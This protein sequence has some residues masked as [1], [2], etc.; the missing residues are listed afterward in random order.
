MSVHGSRRSAIHFISGY[1]FLIFNPI[2]WVEWGGLVVITC[3]MPSVSISS[4]AFL[5]AY[6]FHPFLGS[7]RKKFP[8]MKRRIF[9]L[10]VLSTL[11][12]KPAVGIFD[13]SFL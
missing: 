13:L 11:F 8:L 5:N 1:F 6:L 12:A 7:G 2:S 4:D 9:P 3:F 10:N